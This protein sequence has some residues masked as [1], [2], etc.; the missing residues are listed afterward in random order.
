MWEARQAPRHH[1][2][3]KV[4]CWSTIDH[5]LRLSEKYGM[6]AKPS[7]RG[8]RDRIAEDVTEK[9]WHDEVGAYTA[10]YGDTD[11]DAASLWIGITGLLPPDDPRFIKTV[12]A[13]EAGLRSGPTVYRYLRDD[14]LPG[15][16]GGFILCASWL[17][18]AYLLIGRVAD[19]RELYQQILDCAGPT[20][21]LAEEWDPLA[22]RALGNHP[23]AYSHLGL[24][25]CA[26]LLDGA[27]V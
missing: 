5:A 25:R 10:A 17:A 19:A 20:G 23:Q 11:L 14:G 13:I 1:V 22:E 2:Y 27:K 7:W 26:L 4:M 24:I 12:N 3:S 9:G 21:L 18:E 8:L 16:E 15:T 6:A